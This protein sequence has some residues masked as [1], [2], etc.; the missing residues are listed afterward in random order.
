MQVLSNRISKILANKK[1]TAQK[2]QTESKLSE[3]HK[4][5]LERNQ[6]KKE[7]MAK[8]RAQRMEQALEFK[9]IVR[10]E[11]FERV[12]KIRELE[13]GIIV[14]NKEVAKRMK[15]SEQ[16]WEEQ[17]RVQRGVI[18]E[19]NARKVESVKMKLKEQAQQ[20]C[21]SQRMDR[22]LGC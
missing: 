4:E 18:L 22:V 5:K 20:R 7:L 8:F 1:K 12:S 14:G 2:N 11:R 16:Q 10:K 15:V 21:L 19:E 13:K 17:V 3:S 6:K 9:E